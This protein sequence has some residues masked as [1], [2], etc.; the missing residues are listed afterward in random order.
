MVSAMPGAE[1]E[2]RGRSGQLARPLFWGGVGLTPLAAVLLLVAEGSLLLRI[3]VVLVILAVVLIALS[4]TLRRDGDAVR[5]AEEIVLDE[6]D[7]F[8]EDVRNDIAH[9]VRVAH[10]SSAEKITTLNDT[11][12]ALR[13][14]V[15]LLRSQPDRA[16]PQASAPRQPEAAHGVAPGS[17]GG[18]VLRHTE[19]VHVTTRHTTVV[20]PNDPLAG[21]N[22]SGYSG[23][24]QA[25]PEYPADPEFEA[26]TGTPYEPSAQSAAGGQYG[27]RAKVPQQR[28]PE[29][30]QHPQ[31][32]ESWTEHQLSRRH[33]EREEPDDR[34]DRVRERPGP[35]RDRTPEIRTGERW[36]A[37]RG[38]E[39]GREL[40]MGERSAAIRADRSGTEVRIEDRWA[41][42]RQEEPRRGRRDRGPAD[43]WS[44]RGRE[45][46]ARGPAWDEEEERSQRRAWEGESST[47]RAWQESRASSGWDDDP[48]TGRAWEASGSTGRAWDARPREGEGRGYEQPRGR[49]ARAEDYDGGADDR[50]R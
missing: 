15:D 28:R 17:V 24:R 19:T 49:R 38:D 27:G 7:A 44:D 34:A 30:P 8:R 2:E 6:I 25:K 31:A 13:T 10:K 18:G 21:Q 9:A 33:G 14:Q 41:E 16:V 3:A 4:I 29:L 12:K 22:S 45:S 35:D 48:S 47:G 23:R 46:P 36:A 42:V 43:A 40:R 37:A 50:W 32:R 26:G 11:V 20:D 1:V 5:A 39:R